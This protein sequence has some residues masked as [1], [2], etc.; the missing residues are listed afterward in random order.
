MRH[1]TAPVYIPIAGQFL[2]EAEVKPAT[3]YSLREALTEVLREV[4]IGSPTLHGVL[5]SARLNPA[6]VN[7]RFTL[8]FPI[9]LS[10]FDEE[11]GEAAFNVAVMLSRRLDKGFK[12]EHTFSERPQGFALEMVDIFA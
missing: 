6:S 7:D 2:P 8:E 9:E 11:A 10:E 1:L 4:G 3:S 12:V 5:L